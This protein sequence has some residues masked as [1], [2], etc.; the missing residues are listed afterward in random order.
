MSSMSEGTVNEMTN[1]I[2]TLKDLIGFLIKIMFKM[3]ERHHERVLRGKSLSHS[4]VKGA[5]WGVGKAVKG[6]KKVADAIEKAMSKLFMGGQIDLKQFEKLQKKTDFIDFKVPSSKLSEIM[7]SAKKAG[8]PVFSADIGNNIS[9]IACPSESKATIEKIM[10][11]MIS[12]DA[13]KGQKFVFNENKD[14]KGIDNETLHNVIDSYDIPTITFQ[15]AD[16]TEII[17]VPEEFQEQFLDVVAE[18]KE[19]VR[20]VQNIEI[21]DVDNFVWDDPSTTAIEVTPE[22]AQQLSEYYKHI[23]I[24]DVDGKLYAFGKDIQDDVDAVKKENNAI[25]NNADEWQIGVVDNT[26]TLNEKLLGKEENNKQLVK[27]PGEKDTYILF[28]KDELSKENDGKTFKGKLDFDRDY[29]ICD[30]SGEEKGTTRKGSE[31]AMNFKTRSPLE[32]MLNDSTDKSQYKD[33]INRIELYNEKTNKIVSVP[34]SN[35]DEMLKSIKN[36]AGVDEATAKRMTE[37]ISFKLSKDYLNKYKFPEKKRSDYSAS[38]ATVNKVKSAI[39][40][41]KLEGYKSEGKAVKGEAYVIIDKRSKEY[42]FI[43]KDKAENMNK[44]L[45]G[46]GY[47][48]IERDAII[49]KLVQDYNLKGELEHSINYGRS[50]AAENPLLENVQIAELGNDFTAIFNLESDKNVLNYVAID[51]NL[52]TLELEDICKNELK[53]NDDKAIAD[54]INSIKDKTKGPVELCSDRVDGTKY[55]VSQLTSKFVLISNGDKSVV[56]NKNTLNAEKI[57]KQLNISEKSANK[58]TQKLSASF[59]AN[60]SGTKGITS[61]NKLKAAAEK[62]FSQNKEKTVDNKEQLKSEKTQSSERSI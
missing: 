35:W 13:E 57:A 23:D 10:Q 32:A 43:E 33:T 27:V 8:V 17:A 16:G 30:A 34:I 51:K 60:E 42:I 36:K 6:G 50:L 53:I 38:R 62:I 1:L 31:L 24:V 18:A 9:V 41:K 5:F 21:T 25:E 15:K 49:S 56:L 55:S 11:M 2:K 39:L 19:T 4:A 3:E 20:N 12:K 29:I 14:F 26:I 22:E 40:A 45:K 47:D 48:S 7:N 54:L 37:R 61:L 52:S 46:M 59:K 28:D 44:K 58:I